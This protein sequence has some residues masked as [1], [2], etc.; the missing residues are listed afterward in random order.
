MGYSRSSILSILRDI[1]QITNAKE[2]T[3][4][5]D[6]NMPVYV[7]HALKVLFNFRR[8]ASTRLLTS[9]DLCS[10]YA[11][12]A[13]A[14]IGYINMVQNGRKNAIDKEIFDSYIKLVCHEAENSILI[15]ED[16]MLTKKECLLK[17]IK[18]T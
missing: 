10:Y 2:A 13:L 4:I 16:L 5:S 7:S 6:S 14:L 12:I 18:I 11:I 1:N 3:V 8:K 9:Q 15:A 17:E